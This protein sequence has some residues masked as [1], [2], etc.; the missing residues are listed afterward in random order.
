MSHLRLKSAHQSEIVEMSGLP[1]IRTKGGFTAFPAGQLWEIWLNCSQPSWTVTN[2]N[3]TSGFTP[4]SLQTMSDYV[5]PKF[6]ARVAK[7]EVFF[8]DM[9]KSIRSNLITST[10][11]GVHQRKTASTSCSGTPRNYEFRTEGAMFARAVYSAS[12]ST[13]G[14]LPVDRLLSSSEVADLQKEASTKCLAA[15]G[16]SDSN[17][18]ESVAQIRQT[19]A[20]IKRPLNSIN[21][22]LAKARGLRQRGVSAAEVWLQLRY[23]FLPLI[24]DMETIVSGSKKKTGLMRKTSRA[25]ASL[26]RH[27][28]PTISLNNGIGGISVYEK[29]TLDKVTVRAMALDEYYVDQV[30]NLGFA[31]KGLAALPW[32][33]IPYSF[34]ADWFF[35]LGDFLQALVPLPGVKSLGSCLV[36]YRDNYVNWSLL[37]N[38]PNTGYTIVR[39]MTGSCTS[40][41]VEKT[42]TSI[43]QPALIMKSDFKFDDATRLADAVSLLI[44]R[45]DRIFR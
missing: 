30:E 15:R 21:K 40:S 43:L 8:N 6:H 17:L 41:L 35:N 14:L 11:T 7:G 20:L 23:G 45:M 34:V 42:R 3:V 36:T 26:M 2:S 29:Q 31:T 33:L 9:Y 38:T 5:V 13:D 28:S 44:Q 27:A 25:T 22:L 39:Q 32:E 10:G 12:G 18:F 24:R 4:G 16:Q 19:L 37:S 1:R